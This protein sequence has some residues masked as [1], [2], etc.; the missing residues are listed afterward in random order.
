VVLT[1]DYR[2]QYLAEQVLLE[3]CRSTGAAGATA[4]MSDPATG[5]ILVMASVVRNE[6]G[7]CEVPIYSTALINTFEPGSVLKPVVVAAATEQL[8]LDANSTIELPPSLTIGGQ[9]FEDHPEHPAAPFP[10]WQ[11]LAQSMNVGAITRAQ[12][13]GPQ[14]VYDYLVAF[15]FGQSSGLGLTEG[16][17]SGILRPPED[18]YGSDNGSIPIGQ[19]MTVNAVQLASAYNVIANGGQFVSPVLVKAIRD[20]EGVS[21]PAEVVPARTVISEQTAAE[22]TTSLSAVVEQGTGTEAAI[23]GYR[24]AGKT[25]TA[26]KVFDD[27]SGNLGYGSEGDRRYIVTFAGFLPA[28]NPQ[29]SLVVVV[30]EPVTD[31]T[32]SVVAAPIFAEIAAYG[33]RILGVAPVGGAVGDGQRVRSEPARELALD[34]PRPPAGGIEPGAGPDAAGGIEPGAGP[35]AAGGDPPGGDPGGG[36]PGAGDA[37]EGAGQGV[38]R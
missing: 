16:E 37:G 4:V 9:E 23:A 3:H 28:E 17:S 20:A 36:D 25:G 5:E 26:W 13:I 11:I 2:I 21:H 34:P 22:L 14:A 38:E 31:S 30:D 8:H 15:G 7:G 32:A 19:G 33:A 18:W 35:D 29:L 27:G 10:I 1:L 12:Q 24:V 6:D